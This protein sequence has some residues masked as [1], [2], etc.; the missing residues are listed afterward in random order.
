MADPNHN[1]NHKQSQSQALLACSEA[2][3]SPEVAR[4]RRGSS[5]LRWGSSL[6]QLIGSGKTQAC[7]PRYKPARLGEVWALPNSLDL[8]RLELVDLRWARPRHKSAR[9][10]LSESSELKPCQL[11]ARLQLSYGRSLATIVAKRSAGE[12]NRKA[13]E[14][15]G[16]N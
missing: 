1:H 6:A 16:K 10:N 8:A 3:A 15:K 14:R 13:K 2:R 7:R 4:H 9:L 12:E 5:D 11:V